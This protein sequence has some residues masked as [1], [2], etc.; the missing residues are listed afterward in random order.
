M[1]RGAAANRDDVGTEH[2]MAGEEE[3]AGRSLLYCI[4]PV[5]PAEIKALK[6]R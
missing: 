6:L 4:D 5:C 2:A 3:R 1:V